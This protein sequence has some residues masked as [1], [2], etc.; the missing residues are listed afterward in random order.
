MGKRSSS[1][2]T[3]KAV[4]TDVLTAR[5]DWE[6]RRSSLTNG[7]VDTTEQLVI[8]GLLGVNKVGARVIGQV[9]SAAMTALMEL[10]L[11]DPDGSNFTKP[12]PDE[13]RGAGRELREGSTL[14]ATDDSR[15]TAEQLEYL[16]RP[17]IQAIYTI[18]TQRISALA[19]PAAS[20]ETLPAVG[21]DNDPNTITGVF[22]VVATEQLQSIE[23]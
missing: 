17:E 22:T 15:L 14:L 7:T 6:I 23:S 1:V 16:G 21:R 9:A 18:P 19:P 13:I 10:D 8:A 11:T 2:E 12:K 4:Q 3:S 20:A 5:L